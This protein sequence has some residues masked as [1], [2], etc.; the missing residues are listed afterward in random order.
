LDLY[1]CGRDA[2]PYGPWDAARGGGAG[3]HPAAMQFLAERR[4]APLGS[5]GNNDTAPSVVATI[6]DEDL[7]SLGLG[8]RSS[9]CRF[10]DQALGV[11]RCQRHAGE[12]QE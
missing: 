1:K 7:D 2:T 5:D 6:V 9:L 12:L 8:H 11:V 10:A 3:L 4:L